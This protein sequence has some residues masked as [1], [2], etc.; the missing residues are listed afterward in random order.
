MEEEG[1]MGKSISLSSTEPVCPFLQLTP[2]CVI[3]T[4]ALF[5]FL[6][7]SLSVVLFF[8]RINWIPLRAS[9]AVPSRVDGTGH[10]A[11]R[12]VR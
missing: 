11:V 8:H 5:L 1:G 4:D 10:H 9:M 12:R 6:S 7:F 2:E 3:H